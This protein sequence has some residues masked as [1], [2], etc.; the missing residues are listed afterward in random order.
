MSRCRFACLTAIILMLAL[1]SSVT[2][3][4]IYVKET[5]DDGN[6]G[7]TWNAAKA[8][9][10]GA[11]NA[12]SS[13]DEIWVAAGTYAEDID[14]MDGVDLYGGFAGSE[15]SRS[16]RDWRT[17]KTILDGNETSDCIVYAT[18]LD[19]SGTRIDGFTI[20]NSGGMVGI[21]IYCVNSD[22]T[23]ANCTLTDNPEGGIC[24]CD[25]GEYEIIN[26]FISENQTTID[27]AGIW[28]DSAQVDI[29]NNLITG[30]SAFY[31]GYQAN[32]GALYLWGASGSVVNNTIAGNS[33]NGDGGA[34]YCECSALDI[35][36]NIIASNISGIYQDSDSSLALSHNCV[37]GNSNYAYRTG[38]GG[39]PA[40]PTDISMDPLLVNSAAGNCHIKPISPCR[41]A[42]DDAYVSSDDRDM[43]LRRRIE[44]TH[45]DIGADEYRSVRFDINGDGSDDLI[46]LSGSGNIWYSA[47]KTGW[48][49]IRGSL[50]KMT[51]GDFD[52]DGYD[53][54]AGMNAA[55]SIYR[56]LDGANWAKISGILASIYSGDMTGDGRDDI[57]GQNSAGEIWYYQSPSG[58]WKKVPGTPSGIWIGNVDGDKYDDIVAL[59]STGKVSY[60][61]SA[62]TGTSATWVSIPGTVAKL[63]VGDID[64]D[65]DDDLVGLS[66]NGYVYTCTNR[67]AWTK[68][69]G[70]LASISCGDVNGDGK[71]EIVG[72][73]SQNKVYYCTFQGTSAV[74]TALP[75]SLSSIAIGDLDQDGKDD[76]AGISV[77]GK[78]YFSVNK[79]SWALMPGVL[80]SLF[81]AR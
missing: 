61:T 60:T 23:I 4:V 65:R 64:G 33:A 70:V 49:Q 44:G 14:L 52:G 36:N 13:G 9:A 59:S 6:S 22:V 16:Q 78:I 62:R 43:D 40:H 32:G 47:N 37:Y 12:A 53:D 63:A 67:S 58:G 38:A 50:V 69:S 7:L 45:V 20:G 26:N 3:S 80:A 48:M 54:V 31:N 71:D 29:R 46:G 11:L 35:A 66:A 57:V 18:N 21:G 51:T 24:C 76:I 75:G 1:S 73:T 15:T 41:N 19:I 79:S 30:N 68:V 5:G 39:Q 2:A 42:G 10:N 74:W 27:G 8:T 72:R 34:L 25:G 56:T 77:S 17:N 28:V 81:S 55:G